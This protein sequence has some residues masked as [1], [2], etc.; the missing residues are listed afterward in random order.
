MRSKALIVLAVVLLILLSGLYLYRN[1]LIETSIE[2][3]GTTMVGAKVEIDRLNLDVGRLALRFQRL[4]VTNPNDTWRNLFEFGPSR[5][6]VEAEPLLW[7]RFVVRE[8]SVEEIRFNSPRESDG[9]VPGAKGV[10]PSLFE[11]AKESLLARLQQAPAYDL[12]RLVNRKVN[13][14]SVLAILEIG[15]VDSVAALQRSLTAGVQEWSKLLPTLD[16]RPR[17][18]DVERL[19]KGIRPAEIQT[20]DELVSALDRV[21]RAEKTISALKTDLDA[22]VRKAEADLGGTRSRILRVDD[23]VQAD[24]KRA[25]SKIG[26]PDLSPA[27]MAEML[28]GRAVVDRILGSLYWVGLA[29]QVMPYV[30]KAEQVAK[31]GK[32]ERPPRGRGQDIVYPVRNR[33]P[34]W[35]IRRIFISAAS[36]TADTARAWRASGEVTGLTSHP[37]VYGKPATFV[38]EADIPGGKSVAIKGLLDHTQEVPVDEF[39]LT[40][41][42]LGIGEVA[43]VNAPY[44]P[45]R[46]RLDRL[47]AELRFRLV[48]DDLDLE[49]N[50]VA[51]RPL[52]QFAE[53]QRGDPRVARFVREVFAGLTRLELEAGVRGAVS[54]LNLFVR[55]NVDEVLSARIRSLVG[56]QVQAAQREIER[57]LR[58]RA[59]QEKQKFQAWYGKEVQPLVGQAQQ[60]KR[61]VDDR[62]RILSEMKTQLEERIEQEKKK[63][64]RSVREQAKK[65]L[66]ELIKKP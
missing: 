26:L 43:L 27:G 19:I 20:V 14:D 48:G 59:D 38:L 7:N 44:F 21:N 56:A 36:S 60:Y 50:I 8:L 32:V 39:T 22:A 6:Q 61:L 18:S 31:A 37:P 10:A 12:T 40:A 11:Q 42:G 55:S 49:L 53:T 62:D 65:K 51:P 16:P 63:V 28:F 29:R 52:F 9:A 4:Q 41:L 13:V 15:V 45:N 34:K 24:I 30:E 5:F 54:S 17:L 66:K 58:A 33:W 47:D 2:A 1:R 57:R 25:K 35:L 46:L 23:W 3:A 64:E